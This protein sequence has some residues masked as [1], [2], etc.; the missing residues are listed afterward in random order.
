M[1]VT[2]LCCNMIPNLSGGII[3]QKRAPFILVPPRSGTKLRLACWKK[4][5]LC[6]VDDVPNMAIP[7]P[8]TRT[9][10]KWQVPCASGTQSG[11]YAGQLIH[12]V[13]LARPSY[14]L[15]LKLGCSVARVIS[16]VIKRT[17]GTV[18]DISVLEMGGIGIKTDTH[19]LED[20][21]RPSGIFRLVIPLGQL[22]VLIP[23]VVIKP[24]SNIH[25][26]S[27][28]GDNVI[29]KNMLLHKPFLLWVLWVWD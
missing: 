21:V 14:R 17:S 5:I 28:S 1:V 2:V 27:P 7:I 29:P 9:Y 15:D 25:Y 24:P 23:V 26:P 11:D 3:H 4:V 10:S 8:L 20:L 12:R 18:M 19:S 6:T 22:P 13:D 16:V